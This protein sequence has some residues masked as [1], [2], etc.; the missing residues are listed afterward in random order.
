MKFDIRLAERVGLKSKHIAR[1]VGV[2]RYT[3]NN[4]LS[5]R[6]Q[7][8]EF[9]QPRVDDLLSAVKQALENKELPLSHKL[10]LMPEERSVLLMQI[11]EQY[12]SADE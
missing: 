9:L 2:S 4:W 10:D 1:L 5:G 3:A 7:P 11:I 12:M 8:H 6:R